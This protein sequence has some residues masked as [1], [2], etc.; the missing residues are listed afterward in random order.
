M[1]EEFLPDLLGLCI[2][3]VSDQIHPHKIFGIQYS[4]LKFKLLK[5]LAD[6]EAA[7]IKAYRD[8]MIPVFDSYAVVDED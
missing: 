5:S 7:I 1:Y 4:A 3:F 8:S 6:D 2:L